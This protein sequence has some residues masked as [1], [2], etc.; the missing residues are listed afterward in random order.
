MKLNEVIMKWIKDIIAF[1]ILFVMLC[2]G[3]SGFGYAIGTSSVS[4]NLKSVVFA[5]I[6]IVIL[7]IICNIVIWAMKHMLNRV[8]E[9][10]S[11]HALNERSE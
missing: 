5:C 1:V 8:D 11:R 9:I 3:T 4:I 7:S 6:L 2:I 10:R